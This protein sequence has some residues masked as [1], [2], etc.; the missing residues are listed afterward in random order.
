M[1]YL[2]QSEKLKALSE[3]KR[4]CI[5]YILTMEERQGKARGCIDLNKVTRQLYLLLKNI[6][7]GR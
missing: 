2:I 1:R 7:I 5:K 3:T 4:N 6:C